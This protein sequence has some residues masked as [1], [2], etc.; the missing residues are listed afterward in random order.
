MTLLRLGGLLFNSDWNASEGNEELLNK[1][2]VGDG[3]DTTAI[4]DDEANEITAVTAKTVPVDAD[5]LVLEDSEASFVKKAITFENLVKDYVDA[6][7]HTKMTA[8]TY[9]GDPTGTAGNAN[10]AETIIT[11]VLAANAL[12]Q[13]GDR[14]RIRTWVF[15]TGGAALTITTKL[16]G[17]TISDLVHTGAAEFDLTEA[18][19]HYVDD[20]HFNLIEQETGSGL[21]DL[22]AV[23]VAGSN[24]DAQQDITVEQDAAAGSYATVYGIFVDIF[25]IGTF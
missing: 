12:I 16:N 24:W 25:P 13:A 3:T 8:A 9:A 5:E 21:G 19:V 17:V 1:P 18:W 23:N 15:I 20:T 4:H 2:S 11:R 14:I 10:T 6:Q 7:I 22:T